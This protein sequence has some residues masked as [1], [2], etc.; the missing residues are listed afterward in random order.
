MTKNRKI[1]YILITFFAVFIAIVFMIVFIDKVQT[2]TLFSTRQPRF[3]RLYDVMDYQNNTCTVPCWWG[4]VLGE[5]ETQAWLIFL[6]EHHFDL[7]IELDLA[8]DLS[9]GDG[10]IF[11]GFDDAV[12]VSVYFTIRES[13]LDTLTIDFMNPSAWMD[14]ETD[15]ITFEELVDQFDSIPDVYLLIDSAGNIFPLDFRIL[16][17]YPQEGV[18]GQYWFDLDDTNEPI[19]EIWELCLDLEHTRSIHL[20][21]Q[22][23]QNPAPIT[24]NLPNFG[25]NL[26]GFFDYLPLSDY[27]DISNEDFINFFKTHTNECLS[28]S[29]IP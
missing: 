8:T 28:V 5:T 7:N 4:F 22:S 6:D 26:D 23:P 13:V 1:K 24:N 15:E 20:W 21:L 10:S 2:P 29:T 19:P 12:S 25:R 14:T 18:M 17:V 9:S 3:Q 27:F 16:L 11:V